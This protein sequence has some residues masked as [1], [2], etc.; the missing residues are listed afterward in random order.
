MVSLTILTLVGF[1]IWATF[2]NGSN[3]LQKIPVTRDMNL[4]LLRMDKVFR[5]YVEKVY[6]PFW[7]PDV[8]INQE[9]SD[10][11]GLPY[12]NGYADYKLFFSNAHE[13]NSPETFLV[14][15]SNSEAMDNDFKAGLGIEDFKFQ[16]GPF[17]AVAYEYVADDNDKPIGVS[18]SVTLMDSSKTVVDFYANF[19]GV[20]FW[21]EWKTTKMAP[22]L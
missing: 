5:N 10:M 19:G 18:L 1:A 7:I 8:E 15:E 16:F 14:I 21:V 3:V 4:E 6:I 12:L 20:P 11:L 13:Y 22:R 9:D 2:S 17:T